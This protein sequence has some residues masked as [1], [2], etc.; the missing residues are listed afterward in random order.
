MNT[1]DQ[2]V[3]IWHDV[4]KRCPDAAIDHKVASLNAEGRD[5]EA[6][7]LKSDYDKLKGAN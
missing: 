1:E 4:V 5:T 2:T 3:A 6:H 7:I